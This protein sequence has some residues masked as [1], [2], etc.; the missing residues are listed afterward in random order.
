MHKKLL[1]Y[2]KI[3]LIRPHM[4]VLAK[5]LKDYIQIKEDDC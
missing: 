3:K 5:K 2:P 4:H 1:T